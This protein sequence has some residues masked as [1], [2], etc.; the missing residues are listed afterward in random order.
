MRK[1]SIVDYGIGNIRSVLNAYNYLDYNVALLNKPADIAHAEYL[2]LPGVGNFGAVVRRLQ[3]EDFFEPIAEFIGEGK[4]FLG[5]CVGMQVLFK[6]SQESPGVPGFGILKGSLSHFSTLIPKSI[7]PSIGNF[8]LNWSAGTIH[9][10]ERAYFV[11]NYFVHDYSD[12]ELLATYEWNGFS[13][14][15][16][17]AAASGAVVGVQFHPEK[18]GAQG[19]QFLDSLAKR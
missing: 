17:F 16:A 18:S 3:R 14:P 9:A 13:V 11:H 5:I 12:E 7:T 1:V 2:V 8:N 4:P 15:A 6:D 10:L 19:L